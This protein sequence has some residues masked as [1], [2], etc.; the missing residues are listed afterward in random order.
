MTDIEHLKIKLD[1]KMKSYN[2]LVFIYIYSVEY[3]VFSIIHFIQFLYLAS[4][5]LVQGLTGN[6]LYGFYIAYCYYRSAVAAVFILQ[7]AVLGR[8]D[9]IFM[10]NSC[11]L[12]VLMLRYKHPINLV[13]VILTVRKYLTL[14][15]LIYHLGIY[16]WS[17]LCPCWGP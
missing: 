8:L 1:P 7:R 4:W 15:N 2:L 12:M 6:V 10:K 16:S 5:T 13:S 11:Q 3:I 14:V 9:L 17:R